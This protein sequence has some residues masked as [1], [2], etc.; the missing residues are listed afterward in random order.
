MLQTQMDLYLLRVSSI[1]DIPAM[2]AFLLIEGSQGGILV[3]EDPTLEPVRQSLAE[4]VAGKFAG[5]HGEHVVE[6]FES[7]LLGFCN[8]NVV[9]AKCT[10][11]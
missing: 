9:S 3:E 11:R 1:F 5:G 4:L 6:L 2:G 8:S 7:L 10:R